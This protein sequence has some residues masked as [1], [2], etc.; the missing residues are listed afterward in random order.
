MRRQLPT[1]DFRYLVP[2]GAGGGGGVAQ[3]PPLE[4]LDPRLPD[5]RLLELP[6]RPLTFVRFFDPEPPATAFI[7]SKLKTLIPTSGVFPVFGK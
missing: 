5:P 7:S 4:L 3:Q 1:L 2:Q 6:Q